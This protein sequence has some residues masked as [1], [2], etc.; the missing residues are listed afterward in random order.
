MTLHEITLGVFYV[1]NK[2]PERVLFD[3]LIPL[4]DGT[5]YNSYLIRG[6]DKTVLIDTVD[7]EKKDELLSKLE[8]LG[9]ENIDY[10]V[11]NHAEQDHSGT[12]PEILEK[13]PTAKILATEKCAEFLCELLPVKPDQFRAVADGE[14]I[15]L[16]GKTLKFIHAPWV[17]WPE[18]MLTYLMEDKTL[19]PC[20][21]FGSH[22]SQDELFV[23]DFS[24]VEKSAKRYYAEI[25][26][27]FRAMIKG[28]L[29]KIKS[30]EFD[31]IAP[32]HGPIYKNPQD[33]I[34]AYQKWVSDE[35]ENK[36]VIAYVSM[37]GST[38]K[39]VEHLSKELADRG[40]EVKSF[41]ITQDD[42]GELAMELVD[43]AT[44]VLA[45]P[46]VLVGPHP[47]M[48]YATY[49]A[50]LL[51]PKARFATIIA[52]YGWAGQAVEK[53]SAMLTNLNAEVLPST[54]VRGSPNE[55]DCSALCALSDKILE[56]HKSIG[57]IK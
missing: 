55:D 43:A 12:L 32:S 26:M 19:F 44:I 41:R 17:H 13:Y 34:G 24:K 57:L 4:P 27:P 10:V 52:S 36:V 11:A 1:G 33:I 51:R 16:G 14:E 28:H 50:N 9:V 20:D 23:K 3:E 30:I 47:Q 31:L 40:I 7:P 5:T 38:Q 2:H 39:I 45:T 21:L 18:T 53:L 46:T 29:E 35:V 6:S 8:S 42:I 37:H 49:V 15:S 56:K 48:V 54:V 25:M 22:L